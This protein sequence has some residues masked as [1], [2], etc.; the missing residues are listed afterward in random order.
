MAEVL[1]GGKR[2]NA[3]P[4]FSPAG[5]YLAGIGYDAKWKIPKFVEPPFAAVLEKSNRAVTA[6]PLDAAL[7]GNGIE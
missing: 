6:W 1:A 7:S 3:A 2:E 5:L 4:T